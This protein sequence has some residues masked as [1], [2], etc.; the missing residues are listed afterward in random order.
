MERK[1]QLRDGGDTAF[2]RAAAGRRGY[3]R[4]S[5]YRVNW[6]ASGDGM[7]QCRSAAASDQKPAAPSSAAGPFTRAPRGPVY[8]SG[9]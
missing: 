1:R 4:G 7:H 2:C 9:V 3:R 8:S 5:H 6:P